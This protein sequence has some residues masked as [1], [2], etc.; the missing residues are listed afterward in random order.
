MDQ[1]PD[2]SQHHQSEQDDQSTDTPSLTQDSHQPAGHVAPL[3][4]MNRR[5]LVQSGGLLATSAGV[6]GL[7]TACGPWTQH[8]NDALVNTDP[9]SRAPVTFDQ[10]AGVE[11]TPSQI[12]DPT[13]LRV[14]TNHEAKTVD[15]LTSRILPGTPDDPGAHEAGVVTYIDNFLAYNDGLAETT[16]RQGP[17]A[18]IQPGSQSSSSGSASGGVNSQSSTS[19][20]PTAGTPAAGT[21]MGTPAMAGT[22]MMAGTPAG[23]PTTGTPGAGTPTAMDAN[24]VYVPA[25]DIKRYGYQSQL[26]PLEVYRTG[27]VSVDRFANMRYGA[28]FIA[29]S[30]DQQDSLVGD[31]ANGKAE[32]FPDEVSGASFFQNLRRHTSEGMFCDPVYG[33]NRNM[34]GWYLVGFPGAQRAYQTWEFQQ[35][36]TDRKPQSILDMPM[37]NAGQP[38]SNDNAIYPVSGTDQHEDQPHDR[39]ATGTT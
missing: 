5:R 20:T 11:D 7:A 36:G 8:G 31:M 6:V 3:R 25:G 37:F 19:G 15:A 27:I 24:V 14:L 28:D 21:P 16:Y 1:T 35:E 9:I 4:L 38:M 17:W 26:T 13:V 2:R 32:G 12:P 22:P 33:G 18:A 39:G 30:P 23:T 10:A 34:A 29:L